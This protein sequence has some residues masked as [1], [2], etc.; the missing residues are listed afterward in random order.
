MIKLGGYI[1]L[2]LK[3]GLVGTSQ[4]SFPGNKKEVFG[5]SAAELKKL[6]E[7]LD[8]DLHVVNNTVIEESDAEKAVH[9]CESNSVDFLLLQ[10]T[11]FSGGN[12][13]QVFARIKNA[14]LGLWAIPEGAE[15]GPVPFNSFCGVNMY[16]SIIGHYLKKFNVRFKWFYGNVED[17]L[18]VKRFQITVRALTA[19]KNLQNSKIALIGGV[20]PGFN[21]LYFDERNLLKTFEGMKINRSHEF[22]EIKDRAL[23]YRSEDLKGIIE[24][25]IGDAKG[26]HPKS[27]ALL[28][29]SARIYKAYKDFSEEYGY[30]ALAISCWPKFQSDFRF[31]VCSVIAR[32]NDENTV[33]ACEG[34]L[35]GAVSMLML[36]YI[37]K[38][39]TMLMDVSDFDE[40]DQTIL[41]WHCG[42]A[43]KRFMGDGGY[44]LGVNYH[45]LAH[46]EGKELNCCGIVRDMIFNPQHITIARIT[47]DENKLLIA[48]GDFINY[49]KKSF[50]G[51]RGWLGNLK[52]DGEK[53][54]VRDFVNTIL[55]RRF[56]HHYPIVPGDF[57]KEVKELAAWLN[58]DIVGKVPYEDYMQNSEG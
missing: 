32:L 57:G 20:A 42:P 17:E 19:I 16:S 30:D 22:S 29:T 49:E 34:D 31:S 14:R 26:I 25:M 35:L 36:R 43:S 15:E 12:L 28:D 13:A 18:F 50:A 53:I 51:S 24:E 58:M 11:S 6:S 52:F 56:Q 48:E 41:L 21:D 23:S 10:N 27:Q 7:K 3:I 4:L 38:D 44:T 33:A 40:E 47:G 37:S 2:K 46:E 39:R 55:V 5:R 8:F 1:L 54:S 9:E 45:A